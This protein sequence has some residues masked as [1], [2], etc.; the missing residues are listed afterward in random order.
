M[1]EKVLEGLIGF[2]ENMLRTTQECKKLLDSSGN[3]L[4]QL[5]YHAAMCER[6]VSQLKHR[7]ET[8]EGVFDEEVMLYILDTLDKVKG[9]EKLKSCLHLQ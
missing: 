4:S 3:D 1:S 9:T 6:A 7:T 8:E 5:A 2:F